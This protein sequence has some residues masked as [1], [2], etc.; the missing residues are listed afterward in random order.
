MK[1]IIQ[2]DS[3]LDEIKAKFS[4]EFKGL[5]LE[6]FS[7]AHNK[8]EGSPKEDMVTEN[9]A[10]SKLNANLETKEIVIAKEMKV[11]ELEA[12]FENDFGLH[13]QVFRKMGRSWIETTRTD[14]Y[15]LAEQMELSAD[16]LKPYS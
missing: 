3:Q 9:I 11:S 2:L 1:F 15:S 5:K 6:F 10:L 4:D 12:V 8:L 14:N 7:K 16:S 13:V